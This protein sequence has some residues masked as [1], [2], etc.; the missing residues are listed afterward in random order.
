VASIFIARGSKVRCEEDDR[1][2]E[3]C[4]ADLPR[5]RSVLDIS[6]SA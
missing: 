1:A 2:S 4:D 6:L 3:A 5:R